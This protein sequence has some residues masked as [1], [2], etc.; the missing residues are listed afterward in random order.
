MKH[1]D[2]LVARALE[3]FAPPVS[4]RGNWSRILADA[5]ADQMKDRARLWQL[6]HRQRILA[7]AL[8]AL[9][10]T[11]LPIAPA[12]AG[13]GYFWFLGATGAPKP[14]TE[15]VTV[16]SGASSDRDWTLTAYRSEDGELCYQISTGR[17][18]G[19][20]TCGPEW[21]IGVM[22]TSHAAQGGGSF[23]AGPVTPDAVRV[24]VVLSGGRRLS[25]NLLKAP[26]DL[27]T[28]VKFYF[29]E[30]PTDADRPSRVE[31]VDRLG[32]TI[33]ALDIP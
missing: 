30:L 32:T 1:V 8:V 15:V 26:D 11:T 14:E 23:I 12:L 9:M 17:T 21:P 18:T 24:D 10:T 6:W 28:P 31:A 13:N 16:A 20:A 19:A 22:V 3:E 5:G 25:T 2:P 29:A 4:E 7:L 27:R 33:T